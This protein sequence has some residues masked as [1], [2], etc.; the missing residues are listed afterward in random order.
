MPANVRGGVG[1]AVL[2]LC[3]TGRVMAQGAGHAVGTVP[4]PT[5]TLPSQPVPGPMGHDSPVV[6]E[7]D[8][9]PVEV[10][11]AD[12]WNSGLFV[13]AE[14]LFM[15]PRS[16][17]LDF[18][19]VDPSNLGAPIGSVQNLEWEWN[20]GVRIGGGYR[21]P[22]DGWQ[23]GVY[24]T[25]FH[26]G[27]SSAIGAPP[28][29]TLF[30]TLNHPGDMELADTAAAN[31][32][33]NFNVVDL[34]LSKT[35]AFHDSFTLRFFGGGRYAWVQQRLNAEYNGGDFSNDLVSS[36]VDF[37]GGGLRVGAEGD[38]DFG[39]GCSIFIRASGSLLIGSFNT[40]LVETNNSGATTLVNVTDNFD[41]VIP[42][43]EIGLGFA[44]HYHQFTVSAAY[45]LA[46]WSNLVDSPDFVDD[47]Q[48]GK[49]SRRTS[50]LTL[51]GFIV[52]MEWA[53]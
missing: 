17:E 4:G 49:M 13:D 10:P 9:I 26:S 48:Q 40:S 22:P 8:G 36:P 46:D 41:K 35:L 53:F 25:Y 3:A 15:R 30:A 23:V 5:M 50:D 1:L 24:Y 47:V 12:V 52:R 38:W 43:T 2:V 18:A 31:S 27:T 6:P 37:N 7:T 44:W 19:I 51:D 39:W 21:L 28:G 11:P 32:S 33:V 20:S 14:Y 16:R 45:E 42:V 34:E 29:G